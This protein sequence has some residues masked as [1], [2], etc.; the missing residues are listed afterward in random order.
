MKIIHSI[1]CAAVISSA[2]AFSPNSVK[3]PAS[4]GIAKETFDPLNL[5]NPSVVTKV[6]V[7]TA[8]A[9]VLSPLVAFA[10]EYEVCTF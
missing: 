9:V 10:G 8:A 6:T 4:V 5:A 7:A 2:S 1:T 3:S